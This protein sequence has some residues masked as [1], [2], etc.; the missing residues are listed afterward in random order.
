LFENEQQ[1]PAALII[2]EAGLGAIC[3]CI[4]RRCH[5][6]PFKGHGRVI[7]VRDDDRLNI[8]R[9]P[10]LV[11]RCSQMTKLCSRTGQMRALWVKGP[12][13]L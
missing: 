4:D 1:Q 11:G 10:A 5:I 3:L 6:M 7:V 2:E 9:G 12:F 13:A 8:G